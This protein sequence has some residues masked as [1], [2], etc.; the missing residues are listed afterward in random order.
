MKEIGLFLGAEPYGGGTFQYNQAMLEAVASLPENKYHKRIIYTNKLWESYFEN[1]NIETIYVNKTLFWRGVFLLYRMS[2]FPIS[3]WNH[4]S[5]YFYPLSRKFSK[6]KCDLWIFPSQDELSYQVDVP[7]LSTI[8]DLMHR[9]E[10][11]FPEISAN[12]TYQVR[13]NHYKNMCKYVEGILVDSEVGKKHVYESY[14]RDL[15]TIF[16]LPYIAPKYIFENKTSPDF[17]EKYKLPKKFIF[18]PAQFWKHKNHE[19]LILA[20]HEVKRKYSDI[21]LVLVGSKKNGYKD[22]EELVNKHGLN[23]SVHFLGYVPDEDMPELYRRARA[24]VMPTF[25]GPTNIPQLEAFVLE[26]PVATSNIYGIPEQVGDAALLFDPT[27][28]TDIAN[29]IEQ[30]WY[31]DGLCL[32]LIIKGKERAGKWGQLQF[33]EKVQEIVQDL[34]SKIEERESNS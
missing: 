27:S 30:L 33:N 32:K 14:H 15:E 8:H 12:G 4:T 26:C 23:E 29:A 13:E 24:L 11:S 25:F 19:R 16:V 9:Y 5:K 22:A 10:S 2:K 21:H 6:H 28:V 7:A 3:W 1:K 18:Y 31:D 17:D 20:I 34:L